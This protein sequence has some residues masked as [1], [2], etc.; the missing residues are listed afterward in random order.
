MME[1]HKLCIGLYDNPATDAIVSARTASLRKHLLAKLLGHKKR[2]TVL[3]P[4]N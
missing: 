3:V 1:K 2:V 4:G